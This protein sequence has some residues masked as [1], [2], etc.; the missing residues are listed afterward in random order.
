M[1]FRVVRV[2]MKEE[3]EVTIFLKKLGSKISAIPQP[4]IRN[5][6]SFIEFGIKLSEEAVKK[7]E[8]CYDA[9]ITMNFEDYSARDIKVGDVVEIDIK[10]SE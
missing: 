9:I 7:L 10:I 2:E 3:G 1:K 5:P 8:S 4:D 6:I